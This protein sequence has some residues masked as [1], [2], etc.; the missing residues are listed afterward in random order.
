MVPSQ[1]PEGLINLFGEKQFIHIIQSGGG[2]SHE[3]H[4]QERYLKHRVRDE[5]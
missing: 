2:V 5:I 4:E 1:Q 3:S